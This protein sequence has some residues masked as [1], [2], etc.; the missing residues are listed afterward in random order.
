MYDPKTSPL[1]AQAEEHEL[2]TK[3]PWLRV[4]K[5]VVH[6]GG[7]RGRVKGCEQLTFPKSQLKQVFLIAYQDKNIQMAADMEIRTK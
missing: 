6:V 2:K 5:G 3:N 1:E 7:L 4:L